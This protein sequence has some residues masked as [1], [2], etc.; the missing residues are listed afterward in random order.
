MERVVVFG[1]T[2]KTGI[3]A[4]EAAVKK[5]LDYKVTSKF[6]FIANN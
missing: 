3:A 6:L 1:S 4:V 5:G 2:G